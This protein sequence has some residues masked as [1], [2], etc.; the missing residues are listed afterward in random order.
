MQ[1]RSVPIKNYSM[2]LG[3]RP[4]YLRYNLWSEESSLSPTTA[5]WSETAVPLVRPPDREFLN[6]VSSKTIAENPD[7]FKIV[8]PIKAD[9]LQ[10]LLHDHPN[11]N[12]VKSVITGLKEGFWPWADT[13][14]DGYPETYDGSQNVPDEERAKFINEQKDIEISKGRFS[15]SF[16]TDLLPGMYC[17]P[18]HAVPKPD[19]TDFRMVTDH[20]AGPFS[21]NSMIEHEKVTGY[22]LDNMKNMGEMLLDARKHLP[23]EELEMWK[24]D[25]AEAYRLLPMHPLWQLKQ[26]N[27]VNGLRYVDRNNAFGGSASG[28]IFIA[29]NSLVAWIAKNK[30]KIKYLSNYVDDSSGFNKKGDYRLYAPYNTYFPRHQTRLLELWDEIGIPHKPKKQIFGIGIPVIGIKVDP[31]NMTFTLPDTRRSDLLEALRAWYTKPVNGARQCY[32]LRYWQQMGGWINWAL[33]VYPLLR[34]CLNRFYTKLLGEHDPRRRIWVNNNVREDF[35]WAA[36]HIEYSDGVRILEAVDWDPLRADFTIYCDACPTGMGF[37][38][39]ATKEGFYSPIPEDSSDEIIF[40]FEALCVLCALINVSDR[41]QKGSKIVIYSDNMN[42][43]QIFNSMACTEKF[44]PLLK[45]A[46]DLMIRKNLRVRIFYIPGE[47]NK[48]A[49]ALSRANFVLALKIEPSLTITPFQPPHYA[50]GAIEK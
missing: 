16:G 43:V 26:I 11:Q 1:A 7:L 9:K 24:S 41:A 45:H 28:S 23:N 37:W 29:F 18:V 36:N 39:Y 32:Q 25:I 22:P 5:E 15:P 17:M 6:P 42:T 4:K 40:F 35:L 47:E 10:N 48:I 33:N 8:T 38:H 46:V 50:L 13:L 2:I 49:D 3:A 21:L 19:S 34:P 30:R 20:S 12:F 44:N 31:N 27:T 14:K